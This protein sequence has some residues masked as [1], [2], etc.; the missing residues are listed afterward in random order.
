MSCNCRLQRHANSHSIAAYMFRAEWISE[1]DLLVLPSPVPSSSSVHSSSLIS[2]ASPSSPS[3]T[4]MDI[5]SKQPD[6]SMDGRLAISEETLRAYHRTNYC[7]SYKG[8]VYPPMRV[9]KEIDQELLQLF[10]EHKVRSLAFI[11]AWNPQSK[12][13]TPEENYTSQAMLIEELYMLEVPFFTDCVGIE[14]RDGDMGN[15]STAG[16]MEG[17]ATG[18]LDY[19]TK[20]IGKES[21]TDQSSEMEETISGMADRIRS[22]G[23][24]LTDRKEGEENRQIP[25]VGDHSLWR[26]ESVCVL[27]IT[28][29]FAASLA[30]KYGQMSIL[31]AESSN[32]VYSTKKSD[33]IDVFVPKLLFLKELPLKN[34]LSRYDTDCAKLTDLSES[35]QCMEISPDGNLFA[36]G[37]N[38]KRMGR[39]RVPVEET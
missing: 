30:F 39:K 8:V 24:I 33:R 23:D 29:E 18:G 35:L 21:R 13:Q 7:I 11:T 9:G 28:K 15:E 12:L 17:M 5:S 20:E 37:G 3:S 27:N 22:Q 36:F 16:V 14:S 25:G 19:R 32:G 10:A 38:K 34:D 26:E 6:G 4:G 1:E 31:W 2:S